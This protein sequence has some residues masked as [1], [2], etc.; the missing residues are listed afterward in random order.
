ML[1][2][3]IGHADDGLS[4]S[5][6]ARRWASAMPDTGGQR[7]TAALFALLYACNAVGRESLPGS[8]VAWRLGPDPVA[9]FERAVD[10]IEQRR[11]QGSN[12]EAPGR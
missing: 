4:L 2:Y 3:L 9:A 6:L 12:K 5:L 10:S 11:A 8:A 1:A 7:G